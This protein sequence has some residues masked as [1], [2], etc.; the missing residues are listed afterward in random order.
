MQFMAVLLTITIMIITNKNI[1]GVKT[2]LK[3]KEIMIVIV[4]I[5]EIMGIVKVMRK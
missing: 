4:I 2:I 5:A 3:K 1:D